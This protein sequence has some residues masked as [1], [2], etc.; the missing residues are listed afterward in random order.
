LIV[1][2]EGL[3]RTLGDLLALDGMSFSFG[4]NESLGLLCP[5]GAGKTTT[6]PMMAAL[7]KPTSGTGR[8]NGSDA[9]EEP[10]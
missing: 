10:D 2:V 1:E 6:P 5:N 3:R 7:L 9:A 4:E 8:I